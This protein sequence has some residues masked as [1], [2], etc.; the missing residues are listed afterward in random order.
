MP[1]KTDYVSASIIE[2]SDSEEVV[3][4][5]KIKKTRQKIKINDDLYINKKEIN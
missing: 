5:P 1:L 2:D 3:L 4:E